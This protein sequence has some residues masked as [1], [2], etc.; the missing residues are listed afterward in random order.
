VNIDQAFENISGL[1]SDYDSFAQVFEHSDHGDEKVEEGETEDDACRFNQ[2][3]I[4]ESLTAIQQ[5]IVASKHVVSHFQGG[6]ISDEDLQSLDILS[7]AVH[8]HD[9]KLAR[10]ECDGEN[11]IYM[12]CECGWESD[13]LVHPEVRHG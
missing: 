11:R 13:Y 8:T 10:S 1:I 4:D 7:T 5:L 6:G 2:Y 12:V 9:I 3:D